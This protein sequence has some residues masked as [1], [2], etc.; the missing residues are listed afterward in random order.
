MLTASFWRK[1]RGHVRTYLF[2]PRAAVV[3][4]E[5]QSC[6]VWKC[7]FSL[8]ELSALLEPF[9]ALPSNPGLLMQPLPHFH[10]PT[11]ELAMMEALNV[12]TR[13]RQGRGGGMRAR[14]T[15]I[16]TRA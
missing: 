10:S 15:R 16:C 12:W 6:F 11:R 3:G 7:D 9:Q 14:G 5:C 8:D 13:V 1:E 2:V 4:A